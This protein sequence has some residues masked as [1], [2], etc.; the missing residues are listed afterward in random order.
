MKSRNKSQKNDGN[1]LLYLQK[2]TFDIQTHFS[3]LRKLMPRRRKLN[4][5]DSVGMG[6]Q[7]KTKSTTSFMSFGMA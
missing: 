6:K 5:T 1:H 7:L 4:I 3:L 2:T